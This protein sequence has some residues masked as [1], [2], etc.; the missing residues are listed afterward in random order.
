MQAHEE[1]SGGEPVELTW[2]NI[3]GLIPLSLKIFVLRIL[4][5]GIYYF[6]GKTEVRRRIWSATHLQHQ[7]LEYTGTGKELFLGFLLVLLLF[8]IPD[9]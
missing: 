1:L 8:F 3:P 9:P 7:P 4:T 6:W 2:H 5:L